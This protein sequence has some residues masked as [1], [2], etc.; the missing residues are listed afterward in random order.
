MF[1]GKPKYQTQRDLV[2]TDLSKDFP[3]YQYSFGKSTYRGEEPGEGGYVHA[4]PGVYE[5]V[6]LYDVESMHPRSIVELN[7]FGPYTKNFEELMDG[8]LDCKHDDEESLRKR[9]DGRLNDILDEEGITIRDISN[10]LK[11]GINSVYGLTSAHFDNAFKHPKNQDNIVAKRGA[12]FMIDLKIALQEKGVPVIHIKTDS[13]KIPKPTPEINEF[14]FEFGKRYGYNFEL[15]DTY[16]RLALVNK[17]AYVCENE[18][19]EWE[20]VG[21]QYKEPFVMKMLFTKEDLAIKDFFQTKQVRNASLYLGDRFIGSLAEV[22]ASVTG[23][24]MLRITNDKEGYVS[25][26]KGFKWRLSNEWIDKDDVDMMY[27]KEML[28]K[29]IENIDAVGDAK[30][31]INDIEEFRDLFT[32]DES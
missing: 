16:K 30:I 13:I 23:D 11:T 24:D 18:A 21:A 10:G 31:M 2:Y 5:N 4:E 22:Y 26:T 17:A 1:D 3:G 28:K 27:Y 32:D 9:F 25:G 15:E 7:A 20:A 8:R 19:G 6:V 14:I 29:A 12:L